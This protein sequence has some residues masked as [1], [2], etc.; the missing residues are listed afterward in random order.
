MGL[1]IGL[2]LVE[3]SRMIPFV[4]YAVY[5]A[6]PLPL[7]PERSIQQSPSKI[8]E[9]KRLYIIFTQLLNII[10]QQDLDVQENVSDHP[11]VNCY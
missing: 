3:D 8:Q 6:H 11:L 7:T 1:K 10:I 5:S 9:G 4:D 2:Y